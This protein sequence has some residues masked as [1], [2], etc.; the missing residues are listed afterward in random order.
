MRSSSEIPVLPPYTVTIGKKKYVKYE[1]RD[2]SH[3]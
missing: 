2:E 1:Y 3:L